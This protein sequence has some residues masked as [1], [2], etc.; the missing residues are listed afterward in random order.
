MLFRE[1]CF[2]DAFTIGTALYQ[3]KYPVAVLGLPADP[4][5]RQNKVSEHLVALITNLV[6]HL[7]PLSLD[8]HH[9]LSLCKELRLT[10]ALIHIY[11]HGFSDYQ[12][13]IVDILKMLSGGS[14]SGTS[15]DL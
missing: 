14:E 2:E 15:H 12:A 4:T 8:L 3:G 11:N 6:L 1:G 9:T 5:E 10:N 13:L 7:N